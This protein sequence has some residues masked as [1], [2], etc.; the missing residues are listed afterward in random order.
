M[1][2][3]LFSFIMA[4]IWSSILIV[5]LYIGRRSKYFL[6]F[7]GATSITILYLFCGFRML[8]AFELPFTIEIPIGRF[9]N[10]LIRAVESTPIESALH[11]KIFFI[12]LGIW[13]VIAAFLIAKYAAKYMAHV[14]KIHDLK[15]TDDKT[16]FN[17]LDKIQTQ[18]GK[19]ID[20]HVVCCNQITTP[21]SLGI[22]KKY[23]LLPKV[24][25]EENELYY[26]LLH[27]YMHLKN[28]DLLV[29]LL[30]Q[31]YCCIF[32][33]NPVSYL[34]LKD[35]EQSLEL[36]CDLRVSRSLSTSEKGGY[37]EIILREIKRMRSDLEKVDAM[38]FL[39]INGGKKLKERFKVVMTDTYRNPRKQQIVV[40]LT[41]VVVMLFSYSFVFQSSFEAPIDE[42]ETT[43][44]TY[45][46]EE[47]DIVIFEKADGAYEF[48]TPDGSQVIEKELAEIMINTGTKLEKE[49]VE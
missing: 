36:K 33:W 12:L 32:W 18:N 4:M 49:E 34:L 39:G 9:Y 48:I 41:L 35:L 1:Q 2:V 3:T 42:I 26:I 47:E 22:L 45:E 13:V 8:C 5:V 44:N 28:G 31:L 30:S 11:V 14:K 7:Y 23:I 27:E 10:R 6:Q 24:K 46:I 29:K 40:I 21:L 19:K 17:L 37:L 43:E 25:Y 38:G 15:E 20:V 16:V